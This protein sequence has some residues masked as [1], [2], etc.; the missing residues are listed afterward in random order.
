MPVVAFDAL[1]T[2]FDLGRLAKREQLHRMLHHAAC[3]TLAG[4]W[5]PLDEVAAAVD[6]KLPEKLSAVRAATDA[7]E[8]LEA[9]RDGGGESWIL[10]NGTREST[11]ALLAES[12]L[13][14]VVAHVCT[15][16]EVRRY[17][18]HP[19]VYAM[20]P[21]GSTLIAA[22]GWDIVGARAA[23]Y[24]GV[25]V[26]RDEGEWILPVP[27]PEL[28]ARTLAEAARLALTPP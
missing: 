7:R 5:A 22:H 24:R 8:A 14:D 18:P 28:R 11:D 2:L 21:A 20:L 10:T 17:K 6:E 25:W 23:G 3:L 16:E 4:T 1:G 9:V 15:V 13:A 19:S 26:D 12:N 27:E